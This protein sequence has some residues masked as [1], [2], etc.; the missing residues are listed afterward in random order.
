MRKLR[1]ACRSVR[2]DAHYASIDAFHTR[3]RVFVLYQH[4]CLVEDVGLQRFS[5]PRLEFSLS[6]CASDP[7]P[8]FGYCAHVH[9]CKVVESLCVVLFFT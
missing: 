9:M 4:V 7:R 3:V 2:V 5:N 8:G 1:L 6:N